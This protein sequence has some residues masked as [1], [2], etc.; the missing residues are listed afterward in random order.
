[1]F[2]YLVIKILEAMLEQG[3]HNIAAIDISRQPTDKSVLVF[4]QGE[5]KRCSMMCLSLNNIDKFRLINMPPHLVDLFKQ[6]LVSRWSKGIK[7][8]KV[9]NFSFGNV[10]QLKLRGR[11]WDGDL[12]NDTCHIRSFL[13][14]VIEAFAGQDWRVMMAGDV[15]AQCDTDDQPMDVHSFWFIH[16]PTGDQQ[17]PVPNYGFNVCTSPFEAGIPQSSYPP[18]G[19]GDPMPSAPYPPTDQPSGFGPYPYQNEPPPTY[20]QAIGWN[21]GEE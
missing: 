4:Q 1:M 16:E 5:P 11:P 3:W 21:V 8:E 20:N 17:A 6:I 15:S 7:E 19:Y 13:C 14:N 9:M 18:S 2:R 12:T 10:R